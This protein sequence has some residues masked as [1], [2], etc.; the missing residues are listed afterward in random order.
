MA[1]RNLPVVREDTDLVKPHVCMECKHHR[2]KDVDAYP[3]SGT[4]GKS[5]CFGPT[6]TL[7]LV[8]GGH[9]PI[10][11][12]CTE[13][14]KKEG[15]FCS[16]YEDRPTYIDEWVRSIPEGVPFVALCFGALCFAAGWM[17]FG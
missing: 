1:Y 7:D 4:V 11:K 14:R 9:V 2:M 10:D 8:K 15:D 3:R 12:L 6:E 17:V 5:H 16:F 13:I